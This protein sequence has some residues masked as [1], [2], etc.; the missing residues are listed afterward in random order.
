MEYNLDWDIRNLSSGTAADDPLLFLSDQGWKSYYSKQDDIF[1]QIKNS[2][3]E[4]SFTYLANKGFL[5]NYQKDIWGNE[6]AILKGSSIEF[7]EQTVIDSDGNSS[8]EYIPKITLKG[9][10]YVNE[11]IYGYNEQTEPTPLILN[12]GYFENP[13]YQGQEIRKE[14]GSMAW[15]YQG[16]EDKCQAFNFSQHLILKN[17]YS[18]SGISTHGISPNKSIIEF[19]PLSYNDNFINFGEFGDSENI[20]YNDVF[21]K[22]SS[23][24]SDIINNEQIV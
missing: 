11:M 12:G 3:W 19:S 4:Y 22:V 2:N 21:Q 24:Y 20:V 17:N 13:F 9:N 10:G 18:W 7:V 1:K 8:I 14:D 16:S 5:S 15:V 6:F 23:D